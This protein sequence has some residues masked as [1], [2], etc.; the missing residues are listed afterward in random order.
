DRPV[1]PHTRRRGRIRDTHLRAR[2]R[3][4]PART[5]HLGGRG[6]VARRSRASGP[7]PPAG[8]SPRARAR[9]P[10]RGC[11]RTRPPIASQIVPPPSTTA[12]TRLLFTALALTLL[13][14]TT[15]RAQS[16]EPTTLNTMTAS[17]ETNP[18]LQEWTGPYGGV[19]AFDRMDLEH[20][21]PALEAGMAEHLAEIDA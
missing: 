2:A 7:A 16:D 20:L 12:M 13:V 6:A 3:A 10:H 5:G 15:L 9:L 21:E 11:L 8:F 4:V 14:P 19:P 18:L 17:A 1:H